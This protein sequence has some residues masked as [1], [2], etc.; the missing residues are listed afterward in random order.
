[1]SV[2]DNIPRFMKDQPGGWLTAEYSMLPASTSVRSERDYKRP[3]GNGRVME[4]QR[5]IGRSLR[6][7]IDFTKIPLRKTITIDC[8]V[9][10]ADGSTRTTS[11]NA[12][13]IALIKGI[14]NLQYQKIITDNPIT[15]LIAAVSVGMHH[16]EIH[17]DLDYAIDSQASCDINVVMTEQGDIIEIQG[18]AERKPIPRKDMD[19]MLDIAFD[20]LKDI[21]AT[22]KKSSGILDNTV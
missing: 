15:H 16:D 13:M 19:R 3:Y 2:Q 5:L 14:H 22:I 9:L 8:D 11:I 1:M 7:C 6:S 10:Q 18:A 21:F 4:I 17:V 12:G 20:A